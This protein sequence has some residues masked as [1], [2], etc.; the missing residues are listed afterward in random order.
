VPFG[1]F[2]TFPLLLPA[3][4]EDLNTSRRFSKNPE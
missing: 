3:V 1:R 2:A 4:P